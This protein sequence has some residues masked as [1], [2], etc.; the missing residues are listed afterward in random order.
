MPPAGRRPGPSRT[1]E[2]VLDAA[3]AEFAAR[4]YDAVTLRRVAARAGVDPA[5]VT[6]HFGSKSGL[7]RAVLDVRLDPAAELAAVLTGPLDTV[8][9]RLLTRL[10]VLWD[11]PAGAATIAAVRTALQDEDG[12]A[13]LRD[14]A[15]SQVLRPLAAALT[16]PEEERRWRVDLVASQVVGLLMTRYVL[17]LEP[18]ASAR[19]PALVGA[20]GPTLQRYLT[21]P[22]PA[23]SVEP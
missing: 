13:L 1:R 11:S 12:T 19:H 23:A 9:E 8:A 4:G 22:L 17:G 18:L 7:F 3:R 16:G 15:L 5:M 2:A 14:L 21:G 10:L 20:L 6:H